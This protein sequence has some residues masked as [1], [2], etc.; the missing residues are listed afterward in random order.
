MKTKLGILGGLILV[1]CI[2]VWAQQPVIN[3]ALTD[4]WDST[5]HWL[6]VNIQN[7]SIAVTGTFWQAT[8][9]VSGTFWQATQPVSLASLSDPCSM[10]T[11]K[12]Y[13]PISVTANTQ[14]VAGSS[15]KKVYICS[16]NLIAAAAT[17]VAIVESATSGNAC[18]TSPTGIFGGSTA[19]TGWNFAANGGIALG[20]GSGTVGVTATAA[21]AVCILVSAA[22]QVSGGIAYVQQ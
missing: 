11:A 19:A 18:A 14:L 8:Q 12:S 16:I 1:L 20:S 3:N 13:A 21:D 4:V 5:N 10:A 9:P 17:N 6:K 2:A 7:S 15:S 22:N